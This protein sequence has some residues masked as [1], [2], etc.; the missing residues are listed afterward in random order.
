MMYIVSHWVNLHDF[1]P[2][3]TATFDELQQAVSYALAHENSYLGQGTPDQFKT[4]DFRVLLQK[5]GEG[6]ELSLPTTSRS[7]VS[8]FV[9]QDDAVRY[10]APDDNYSRKYAVLFM[11]CGLYGVYFHSEDHYYRS[12]LPDNAQV[13]AGG[14]WHSGINR[15]VDW[16]LIGNVSAEE[17][18]LLAEWFDTLRANP[19]T[20]TEQ[21]EEGEE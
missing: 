5:R 16:Q 13:F 11:W 6:L 12:Y 1:D 2:N 21:A 9:K 18:R 4:G 3:A 20:P 10:S 15:V 7:F 19:P 14:W 17:R 8:L